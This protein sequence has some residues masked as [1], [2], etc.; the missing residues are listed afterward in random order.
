MTWDE[1]HSVAPLL[2][3]MTH[4]PVHAFLW[5]SLSCLDIPKIEIRQYIFCAGAM[6]LRGKNLSVLGF[7]TGRWNHKWMEGIEQVRDWIVEV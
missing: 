7:N 6:N 1:W 4:R 3:T 2:P 5:V